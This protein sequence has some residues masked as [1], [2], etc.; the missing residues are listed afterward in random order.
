MKVNIITETIITKGAGSS[1]EEFKN[2]EHDFTPMRHTNWKQ[3]K[4]FCVKC[5][6]IRSF[7]WGTEE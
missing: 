7:V 3:A 5:T 4:D 1:E 6:A 2:C